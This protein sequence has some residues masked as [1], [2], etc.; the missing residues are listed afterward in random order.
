[1]YHNRNGDEMNTEPTGAPIL[2]DRTRVI[3]TNI[4]LAFGAESRFGRI[5][6]VSP[7][8]CFRSDA[9]CTRFGVPE[10]NGDNRIRLDV[11]IGKH[12]SVVRRE[13][14]GDS[15]G[16]VTTVTAR[17]KTGDD[18]TIL[19]GERDHAMMCDQNHGRNGRACGLGPERH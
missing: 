3:L 8:Q 10:A 7:M 11:R 2:S 9:S 5:G 1:M 12:T 16:E 18:L 13:I 17:R 15:D 6:G 4:G 14:R 19:N